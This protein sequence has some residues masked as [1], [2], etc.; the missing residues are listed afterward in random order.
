MHTNSAYISNCAVGF[1]KTVRNLN[2]YGGIAKRLLS[3]AEVLCE[4]KW[5]WRF[6]LIFWLF[7][8]KKK[9][10]QEEKYFLREPYLV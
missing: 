6:G 8:I 2:F 7:F 1:A 10:H 3:E 5:I 9:E 4:E